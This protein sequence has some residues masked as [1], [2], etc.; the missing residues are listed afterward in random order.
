MGSS[1]KTSMYCLK[2]FFLVVISSATGD[3]NKIYQTFLQI[4]EFGFNYNQSVALDV[5]T[6]DVIKHVPRHER[7]GKVFEDTIEILNAAW[8]ISVWREGTDEMCYYRALNDWEIP[9]DLVFIVKYFENENITIHADSLPFVYWWGD[10]REEM[11]NEQRKKA[12]QNVEN[13]CMNLAILNVEMTEVSQEKF[14]KN[15]IDGGE[16]YHLASGK[17]KRAA[18]GHTQANC[19]YPPYPRALARKKRDTGN[20]YGNLVH[21]VVGHTEHGC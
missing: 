15:M 3:I 11:T 10:V 19:G 8:G 21:L 5:E 4:D 9:I 7:D 17:R 18:R 20:Q 14:E 12:S 2:L 6:M 1:V 16:C 13:L